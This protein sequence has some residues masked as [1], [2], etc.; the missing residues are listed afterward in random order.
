MVEKTY[1]A[2][3][4]GGPRGTEGIIDLPLA[5][6]PTT[7]GK[8]RVDRKEGRE[9]VT[10]F[11]VLERFNGYA[12]VELRPKTGRMHQI[13]VH[14]QSLGTP[15]L[16]DKLYGKGRGFYLS[17]VKASYKVEGDEKPLLERTALHA[18]GLAFLHPASGARV[19]FSAPMPKDMNSVLRYLRK[20]RELR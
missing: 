20:F 14:L 18:S 10:C 5:D 19:E 12:L 2:I 3:V 1:L 6:D 13:R 9:S 16:A 4:L 17:D 7:V 8:I 11:R 15:I